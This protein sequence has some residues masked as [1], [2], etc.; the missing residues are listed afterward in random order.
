MASWLQYIHE[1]RDI[2]GKRTTAG[3]V[4]QLLYPG[5]VPGS[6]NSDTDT[7]ERRSQ[8]TGSSN[9]D[10]W[11]A[12]LRYNTQVSWPHRINMD[13]THNIS[14]N[15]SVSQWINQHLHYFTASYTS[16][17]SGTRSFSYGKCLPRMLT[18]SCSQYRFQRDSITCYERPR[19]Y[20]WLHVVGIFNLMCK[21]LLLNKQILM[22]Q[23]R[24]LL[25]NYYSIL[26]MWITF[27]R[28]VRQEFWGV[29]ATE[30]RSFAVLSWI[31]QWKNYY[32]NVSCRKQ[33]ARQHSRKV[34]ARARACMVR[35]STSPCKNFPRIYLDHAKIGCCFLYR[36][37]G[38]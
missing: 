7:V 10:R 25:S 22:R 8:H 37:R 1:G 27:Y 26:L 14:M 4:A 11:A 9:T 19:I 18:S 36:V 3:D 12:G 30:I 15:Q 5:T 33:I 2:G 20:K 31:Q 6:S 13:D 35:G 24:Q 28:A 32:K 23:F 17:K 34:L 38:V 16:I 29:V 21:R